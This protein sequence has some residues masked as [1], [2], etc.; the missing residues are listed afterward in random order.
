MGE[1]HGGNRHL[2]Q[3]WVLKAF[4]RVKKKD[5]VFA[6]QTPTSQRALGFRLR[7][8]GL[9]SSPLGMKVSGGTGTF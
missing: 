8:P 4:D 9:T 7:W 5:M 3:P 6:Q 1:G 2:L